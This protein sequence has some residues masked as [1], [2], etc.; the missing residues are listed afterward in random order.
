MHVNFLR[1]AET[2]T[3]WAGFSLKERAQLFHRAYP[4]KQIAVTTLRRLYLKN[5]VKIKKVRQ[6]KVMPLS[7][8]EQFD[9]NRLAALQ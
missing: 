9:S 8:W 1:D 5:G 6:E 4:S 3:K 7:A 2:L